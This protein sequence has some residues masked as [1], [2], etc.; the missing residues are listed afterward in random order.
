MGTTKK[1]RSWTAWEDD[2]IRKEYPNRSN[3]DLAEYLHRSPRAVQLRALKLGVSKTPEFAER[4]RHKGQFV[5]GQSAWNKGKAQKYWL[6]PES[7]KRC[8]KG[9]FPK[10]KARDDNPNS[11]KNK[12]LGSE[13]VYAD[14]YVWVI[15]EHGRKQKHRWVWEQVH[16]HIPPGYLVKFR[17][18]N[19]L[20]CA[21][22]NLYLVSRADH[23]RETMAAL[24]P[25]RKAE[26]LMKAKATRNATIRRD[27]LRLKWGLEPES[28]L[29]K[30]I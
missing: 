5:K 20:N 2:Y 7:A 17:D 19:P 12:P 30:R 6:S 29:V 16:G 23:A 25:E 9:W 22:D 4:Q 3:A 10:G 15:T 14:G 1:R 8:S 24:S 21:I 18:G 13:R 28:K 11:C 26:I 27:K